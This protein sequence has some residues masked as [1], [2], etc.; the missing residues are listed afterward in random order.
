MIAEDTALED[1]LLLA[2]EHAVYGNIAPVISMSFGLCEA[3]APTMTTAF[4]LLWEQA[5]AQG[6]TVMVSSGDCG[7]AGVT[8]MAQSS[9]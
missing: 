2:A 6:I 5:A 9:P 8:M 1:G 3:E 4:G 7:S